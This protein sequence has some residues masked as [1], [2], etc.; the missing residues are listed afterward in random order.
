MPTLAQ[1]VADILKLAAKNPLRKQLEKIEAVTNYGLPLEFVHNEHRRDLCIAAGL[2]PPEV[3]IAA[4]LYAA[5]ASTAAER[6][7]V[8][9]DVGNPKL[10]TTKTLT[11]IEQISD[12]QISR[13]LMYMSAQG[14]ST[15]WRSDPPSSAFRTV[16]LAIAEK[17]VALTR[18]M[19]IEFPDV[20]PDPAMSD[21]RPYGGSG[22][23]QSKVA[24]EGQRV[25]NDARRQEIGV[26]AAL[27]EN[28]GR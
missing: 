15:D 23:A 5:W 16:A 10:N 24:A 28:L 19:E 21:A 20:P 3:V 11:D 4:R 26:D 6:I 22:P 2:K 7:Q 8:A 13:L 12:G 9:I 14:M 17:L 1:E 18:D 25:G 27:A